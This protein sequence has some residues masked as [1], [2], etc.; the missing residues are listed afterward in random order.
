MVEV[1]SIQISQKS[2]LGMHLCLPAYPLYLIMSTKA[3]LVQNMFDINYFEK[4][5]PISVILTQY[6]YGYEAMLQAKVIAMNAC[7]KTHGVKIHMSG[8]EA[9]LLCERE[10][11][12]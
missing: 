5:G 3:I 7:A 2:F 11:N 10:E 9:L 12:A 1:K 6:A 8:K 4:E